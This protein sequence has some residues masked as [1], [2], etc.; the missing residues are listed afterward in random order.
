[1]KDFSI[2]VI[3]TGLIVGTLDILAAFIYYVIKTGN[4][5]PVNLLKYVASGAF[6]KDA[7]S[8]GNTMII[9]GLL[10]HYFIAIAFTAF[11]FL[12]FPK[13]KSFAQ[14]K[15]LTGILLG[16]FIWTIMNLVVIPLSNI[17]TG[18]FNLVNSLI[19]AL[20]LICCIGL[21]LSFITSSY[22]SKGR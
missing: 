3:K 5:S 17:P 20:I 14:N 13:I 12:L 19:N 18:P 11:F 16:I 7:F 2:K 15:T 9:A 22:Y 1:M 10:F 6:G 8:G 21:P 4:L